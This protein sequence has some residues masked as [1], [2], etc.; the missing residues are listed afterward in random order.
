MRPRIQSRS[1]SDLYS[2][3]PAG[4]LACPAGAGNGVFLQT[5]A[6]SAL[7]WDLE[8]VGPGVK[9][10]EQII[11]A[12]RVGKAQNPRFLADVKPCSSV[13]RICVGRRDVPECGGRVFAH[14]DQLS[15]RSPRAFGLLHVGHD[16]PGHL[17]RDEWIAVD[18]G[19]GSYCE[20]L[21]LANSCGRTHRWDSCQYDNQHTCSD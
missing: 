8:H 20:G 19:L 5:G 1:V 17:H 4:Q 11:A 2:V 21:F 15:H 14:P 10:R 7:A 18:V 12:M 16:P 9:H 6:C 13:E 3:T